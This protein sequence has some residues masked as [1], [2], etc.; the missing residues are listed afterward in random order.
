MVFSCLL[1]C[2]IHTSQAANDPLLEAETLLLA[3]RTRPDAAQFER[4]KAIAAAQI[5]RT[6][7][8]ARAWTALAW[9]RMIDHR[10]LEALEAAKTADRLA[11]DD[12]RTQA[13]MCDALVELGRYEEAV[14]T[15]QRLA[16]LKPGVPA[17]IRAARMRFLY[18]D[19]DGAI[20]LMA[21]AA[22]TGRASGEESAWVWLELAR[23]YLHAGD[24]VSA[25]QS[26]AAAQ[27]AYPGLPAILPAKARLLLAQGDPQAALDLYRQ[28]LA[29]QPSAEE[30]LAA[31]RLARHLG[32]KG[33]AK[34]YATLLEGLARLDTGGLSRRA[35]AEYFADSVQTDRALQ[36]AREELTARPDIYSHATLAKVLQLAGDA[37]KAQHHAQAAL[38]LNTPDPQLQADM[39]A[40]LASLP[41]AQAA[42]P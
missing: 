8:E 26:I 11:A 40:I 20:Q 36:L 38:A 35:L 10:F 13:L 27:Q 29:L 41:A 7:N 37:P 5:K 42:R 16:D 6:P 17:W 18:N 2:A 15:A 34:H 21:R 12:P 22:R 3:Q 39:R 28:A 9:A 1:A 19:T 24:A 23:L 31:W 25:G 14:T 30:A 32:E 33:A 4:A